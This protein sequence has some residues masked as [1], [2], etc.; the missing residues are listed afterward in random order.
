[1]GMR[2][3]RFGL[4]FAIH[5]PSIIQPVPLIVRSMYRGRTPEVGIDLTGTTLEGVL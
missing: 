2:E 5:R 1:M 3:A 4:P